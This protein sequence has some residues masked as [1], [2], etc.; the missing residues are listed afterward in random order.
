MEFEDEQ[1]EYMYQTS[2]KMLKETELTLCLSFAFH[3]TAVAWQFQ[4]VVYPD[5]ASYFKSHGDSRVEEGR[6][7]TYILLS[8]NLAASFISAA[9]V[10]IYLNWSR[11]LSSMPKRAQW[12]FARHQQHCPA[13]RV[14]RS[15]RSVVKFWRSTGRG[16]SDEERKG[17]SGES[18]YNRLKLC[19]WIFVVLKFG[20]QSLSLMAW[21]AWPSQG[22]V[23]AVFGAQLTVSFGPQLH[24]GVNFMQQ[25]ILATFCVVVG[26]TALFAVH[27]A[28]PITR[29]DALLYVVG[30]AIVGIWLSLKWCQNSRRLWLRTAFYQ[31]EL[32]MLSR[33]LF[34]LVPPQYASR[35][36]ADSNTI[37]VTKCRVAVLQVDIVLMTSLAFFCCI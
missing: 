37:P 10:A 14:Y 32:G 1:L 13:H 17:G 3:A 36:I 30:V 8:L 21:C 26:S 27:A 35:L 33:L 4:A 29:L 20:S 6:F 22:A 9:F 19:T 34:D 18:D 24:C 16:S 31:M 12:W 2:P 11:V 28:P 7:Y 15:F 25:I 23:F 5:Y